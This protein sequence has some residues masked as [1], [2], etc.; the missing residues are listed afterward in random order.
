[1]KNQNK[2]ENARNKVFNTQQ[3]SNNL[4]YFRKQG[5]VPHGFTVDKT[6]VNTDTQYNVK[7]KYK[8]KL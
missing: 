8:S 7:P 5:G 2:M 4:E 3:I 6:R 1:M